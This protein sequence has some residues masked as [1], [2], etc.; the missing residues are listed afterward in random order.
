VIYKV[1]GRAEEKNENKPRLDKR[2]KARGN[3]VRTP[4]E[5]EG[6]PYSHRSYVDINGYS[7]RINVCT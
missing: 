7:V 5:K 4:Q 6:I 2:E 3:T 1:E